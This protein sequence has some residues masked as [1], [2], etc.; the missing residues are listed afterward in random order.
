MEIVNEIR[1]SYVLIGGF[2]TFLAQFGAWMQHNLQFKYPSLTPE[3]WGWYVLAIP[4][5]WLFLKATQFTVLGFGGSIWANRFMGF[6]IGII[7]YAILTQLI[8]DQPLTP[9]ILVQIGLA[10]GIIFTQIFWK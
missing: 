10:I 2:F 4:L 7:V 1:W 3:W 8:F 5:T 6:S 9:K